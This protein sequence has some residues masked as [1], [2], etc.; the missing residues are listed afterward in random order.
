LVKVPERG[1]D[2]GF[3]VESALSFDYVDRIEFPALPAEECAFSVGVGRYDDAEEIASR[4]PTIT[5]ST[6]GAV[7]AD[8]VTI[9]GRLLRV[10]WLTRL[11][12][13]LGFSHP[14]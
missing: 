10:T 14:L 1:W 9:R 12:R 11:L 4:A 2:D 6:S 5:M 13:R 7:F 3:Y 8:N